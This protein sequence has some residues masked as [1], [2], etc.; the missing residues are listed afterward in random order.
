MSN[1][2]SVVEIQI[3]PVTR[4]NVT[5]YVLE[6]NGASCRV[7]GEFPGYLIADEIAQAMAVVHGGVVIVHPDVDPSPGRELRELEQ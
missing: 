7:I 4:Y 2:D 5:Q 3:R 1:E 6:A